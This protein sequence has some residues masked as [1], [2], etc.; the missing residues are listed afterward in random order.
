MGKTQFNLNFKNKLEIDINGGTDLEEDKA[1]ASWASLS[2]GINTITPAAADTT[3]ATPYWDG[4]GFTDTDVTGKNITFALS[5]HRVDGDP[6]QDYVAG[7]FLDIGDKLRTLARWT[8]PS[9]NIVESVATLTS[10]VP[11]GGAANVKQTFSFT[12]AL[13]GKPTYTPAGSGNGSTTTITPQPAQAQ[14]VSGES[15]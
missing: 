2:K 5:G 3:D 1:K 9:G 10:I 14:G 15:K 13:N 6:A 4:D 7:H 11:F 8:D 12:L